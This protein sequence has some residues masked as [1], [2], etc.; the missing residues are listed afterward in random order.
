MTEVVYC[1]WS[2]HLKKL[3]EALL[4]VGRT[5]ELKSEHV[6]LSGRKYQFC[7]SVITWKQVHSLSF[8]IN[9]GRRWYLVQPANFFPY[10]LAY[11]S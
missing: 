11:L 8:L 1:F 5:K 2:V 3:K 6:G 4:E 9:H 7:C 10:V